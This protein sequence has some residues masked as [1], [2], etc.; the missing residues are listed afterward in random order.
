MILWFRKGYYHYKRW[1]VWRN[2]TPDGRHFF[3]KRFWDLYDVICFFRIQNGNGKLLSGAVFGALSRLILSFHQ[4]AQKWFSRQIARYRWSESDYDIWMVA[5]TRWM[6]DPIHLDS[7][8]NSK[9]DEHF[10]SMAA[11]GTI[12]FSSNRPRDGR[13]R[14]WDIY[15]SIPVNGKI[16][17]RRAPGFCQFNC[18]WIGLCVAPDESF[19]ID[20]FLRQARWSGS[21]IFL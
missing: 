13:W 8:V 10:A 3:S 5:K 20:W 16:P 12:Y 4:M 21:L 11:N 15:R 2:F 19:F 7:G 17:D 9:Y 14:W 6:S 18:L 1:W